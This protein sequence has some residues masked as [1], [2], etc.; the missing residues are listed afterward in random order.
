[1]SVKSNL[2][3]LLLLPV[4]AFAHQGDSEFKR[5]VTK[6]FTV[7]NKAN[8]TVSNKYGKI[9]VHTW[10]KN[11][12]KATVIITGFGK[13]TSEAQEIANGVDIQSN[14]DAGNVTMQ[15]NYNASSGSKWFS[16]GNRKDSKDYVNI[17]YEL[18]V[19]N[20][21]ELLT[22]ENNFGDVIT[23]ALPF[24]AKMRLNYCFYAIREASKT[25]ELDMNYCSKGKIDKAGNLIIK[26]N[27]SDIRCDEAT[28]MDVKSNYSDYT[29]GTLGSLVAKSNY[30]DYKI[31]QLGSIET[32]SNYSDFNVTN[33]SESTDL[34]LVY[35][36]FKAKEVAVGYKGGKADLTYSD[37]KLPINTKTALRILVNLN[38][39]ELEIDGLPVKNVMSLKKN[40]SLSYAATTTSGNDQSPTLT[41]NGKQSDVDL[42]MHDN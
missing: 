27:Y 23:D 3:L 11:Q 30:S 16:W 6:E 40:T 28:S 34:R 21:L 17:D 18:Y 10:P 1:M 29:L 13:N 24:A 7:N 38:Y 35:G 19:P 39:G 12:I 33:L 14:A 37:L 32:S 4:W 26:A 8:F 41:I 36:D 42:E 20:N 2:L 22:L 15:T 9:I 5:T 31:R 25:L